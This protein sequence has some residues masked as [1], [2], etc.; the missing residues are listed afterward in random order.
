MSVYMFSILII[1]VFMTQIVFAQDCNDTDVFMENTDFNQEIGTI[2]VGI[3][4]L[5]DTG[6][7][8]ATSSS[9]NVTIFIISDNPGTNILDSASR[10]LFDE[11]PQL[12]NVNIYVRSGEQI[13]TMGESELLSLL[14]SSDVFIGEWVST[15][16]DAVLTSVVEKYPDISDKRVFLTLELP[17]GNL[18]SGS[19]SIN[20]IKHN[21]INYD[22]IFSSFSTEDIVTYFSNTMR[23]SSY[24]A[25]ERYMKGDGARFDKM[26]NDL[27]LYKD[28]ND[29]NSMKNQILYILKYLGYDVDYEEPN[30]TGSYLYGIYR[31][32]WFSLD[33]YIATYF[34][35]SKTRTVG[36][37]ESTM[38]VS[39][40]QLHPTYAIIESLE[41]KGYNV[42]PVFA[43]GGTAEQLSVMVESFTSAGSDISGFLA[44]SSNYEIYVD[45]IISMVA[46]GVGGENFTKT[47]DFFDELGVTVFR[48]V[49]SDYVSNEQWELGSTGLTTDK[50][51]KWWHVAIAEAQGIIGATFIGGVS[52]YISNLT[53]ARIVTYIPHERNIDLLTDRVDSWVDL[54]YTVNYEKVLSIIYYNYPPGKHN[55]GSSYL[56]TITSIYNILITLK[57]A[58]YKVEDLPNNVSELE[59]MMLKCGINV[60][61][62]APGELQKLANQSGITLLPVSEYTEWFNSLDDIIKLQVREGPVAYI[63]ELARR[64]V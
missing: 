55:I 32:R 39:S 8:E 24:D 4:S 35:S 34:D 18:N 42:I 48:A 16:V 20:L 56:D 14:Y 37:L 15:D 27:V 3:E 53:G 5:E 30:F 21:T 52:P 6:S 47:I 29:K 2:D 22:R 57:A 46:Y 23:G 28:I 36:I 44:N 11:N 43:A 26:F 25:I 7:D 50:S 38:Y 33:E 61:N 64:A 19:S 58:G 60:A 49:H 9:E 45:A 1:A 12:T 54:R 31:E 10:E 13:K 63:G 40:Q 51:D 17:S 62:W 41:S 59:D